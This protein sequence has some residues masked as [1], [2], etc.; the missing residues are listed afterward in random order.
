MPQGWSA[1]A[2]K[3]TRWIC[4]LFTL[5]TEISVK[6]TFY[7]FNQNY[8][9]NPLRARTLCSD[10]CLQ[11][12]CL[13]PA[14]VTVHG[15]SHHQLICPFPPAEFKGVSCLPMLTGGGKTLLTRQPK[16]LWNSPRCKTTLKCNENRKEMMIWFIEAE[17]CKTAIVFSS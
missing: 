6:N 7:I 15:L 1:G 17:L 9:T 13:C 14:G 5:L 10:L 11:L 12:T 2:S 8:T 3:T 16:C 4:I